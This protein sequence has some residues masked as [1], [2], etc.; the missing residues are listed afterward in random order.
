MDANILNKIV[1]SKIQQYIKRMIHYDKVEF[2][3]GFQE[4]FNIGK[5]INV[6]HHINKREH[7]NHMSLWLAQKKHLT[8]YNIQHDKTP[9]Q[10]SYRGNIPRHHKGHI[11]KTH[12][13]YPQRAKAESFS[14]TVRKMTGMSTLTTVI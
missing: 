4:L 3:P 10:S 14:Y 12:S 5:S 1:A 7:K 2:F 6:I 11:Q 9:Q 13:Q 8:K